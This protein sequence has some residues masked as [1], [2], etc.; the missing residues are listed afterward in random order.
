MLWNRPIMATR[1]RSDDLTR[2]QKII[3]LGYGM[4]D[5]D[6]RELARLIERQRADAWK[7]A[8]EEEA[9]KVGVR[10]KANAPRM[11]DLQE[12]RNLSQRDAASVVQT[13]NRDLEREIR[14]LYDANPRGNRQYY[15][16]NLERWHDQRAAWKNRQIA[17]Y[18]QKTARHY[19][20][21]RFRD[22]NGAYGQTYVF[23]GPAPVCDD[24]AEQFAAGEVDQR[25]VDENPTPL[26]P[27][28]PHEWDAAGFRLSVPAD[29][30]WTG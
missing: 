4:T 25:H 8:L 15:M 30:L 14:R 23:S 7:T 21:Q 1:T 9:A 22:E 18:S 11:G 26:H 12:L 17:L 19:A 24:C 10:R 27:N 16:S 20:Q 29:Q 5:G 13:Y 6:E 2:L 28:C 3:R